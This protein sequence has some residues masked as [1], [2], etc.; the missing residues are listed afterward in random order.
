[1]AR[2]LLIDDEALVRETLRITLVK[3]GHAVTTARNGAE[4]LEIFASEPADLVVTDILMPEKEGIET[5]LSLRKVDP[6]VGIIAIS[7]GD[8]SGY[9]VLDIAR[10]LG[11]DRI[12]WKPFAREELLAA[13]DEL[14]A[15]KA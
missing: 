14:L 13:V 10:R 2:I 15:D 7:G 11:A 5:I 12:L 8:R 3:A 6:A 4:G 1:M 9:D